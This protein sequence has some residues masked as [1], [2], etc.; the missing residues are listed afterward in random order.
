MIR[1]IAGGQVSCVCNHSDASRCADTDLPRVRNEALHPPVLVPQSIRLHAS[2][3]L[4]LLRFPIFV[5]LFRFP[6]FVYRPLPAPHNFT[7]SPILPRRPVTA[8]TKR[9]IAAEP[10]TTIRGSGDRW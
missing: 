1:W 9:A 2:F 7:R 6:F 8:Q 3:F 5:F 10:A 4:F